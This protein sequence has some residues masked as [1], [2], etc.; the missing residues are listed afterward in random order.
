MRVA[1]ST[2][3]PLPR[4]HPSPGHIRRPRDRRAPVATRPAR[5]CAPPQAARRR[6]GTRPT[7]LTPP[8]AAPTRRLPS[9]C[10][11]AAASRFGLCWPPASIRRGPRTT[12]RAARAVSPLWHAAPHSTCCCNTRSRWPWLSSP[13]SSRSDARSSRLSAPSNGN[14]SL[15]L[16]QVSHDPIRDRG[17]NFVLSRR[18]SEKR[19][20]G[21]IGRKPGF[22]QNGWSPRRREHQ[23]RALLYSPIFPRMNSRDLSLHQL[24]QARRLAQILIELQIALEHL[25]D[26]ERDALF[27][28]QAGEM[29]AGISGI[30]PTVPGIDDNRG[31]KP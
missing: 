12:G 16:Q 21:G 27:G 20:V 29:K 7:E 9:G 6:R 18:R 31:G 25:A 14:F 30:N 17:R 28:Q 11:D 26:A 10:A 22:D 19:P 5:P 24:R 3:R 4:D 8:P 1:R 15:E 2:R 13:G 23:E